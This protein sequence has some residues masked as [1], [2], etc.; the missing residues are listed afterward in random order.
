[1]IR[2]NFSLDLQALLARQLLPV[3][4]WWAS[5]GF[6]QAG[7]PQAHSRQPPVEKIGDFRGKQGQYGEILD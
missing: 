3:N 6:P 7:H 5:A 2:G 4:P 1:L